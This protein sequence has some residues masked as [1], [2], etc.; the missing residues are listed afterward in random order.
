M[1]AKKKAKPKTPA[2]PRKLTARQEMFCERLAAGDSQTDAWI[3]AG[4]KV[5]REVAAV[6]ANESLRNPKIEERVAALRAVQTARNQLTKARKHELLASIAENPLA[7][8]DARI[9]AM[10]EDSKM[11]G[12]YEPEHHVVDAG[13]NTIASIRERAAKVV[14]ALSIAH[15][16]IRR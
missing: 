7:S 16:V 13:P 9:R 1:P 10:A 4:Y 5:S 3:N 6:N 8:L 2:K 11:A 15:T 14:S 12:H